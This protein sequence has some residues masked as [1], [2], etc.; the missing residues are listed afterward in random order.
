MPID[1]AEVGAVFNEIAN[2]LEIQGANPFRIGAYRNAA[3]NIEGLGKSV[4]AM[5]E[6]DDDLDA[7]PGIGKFLQ[8]NS[9]W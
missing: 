8:V 5:V 4:E 9:G 7:L 1:N 3:R 6:R 2:L